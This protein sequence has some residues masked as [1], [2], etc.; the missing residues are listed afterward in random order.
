MK[1]TG[2]ILFLV[3]SSLI[4]LMS[5][6]INYAQQQDFPRIMFLPPNAGREVPMKMSELKID[7]KVVANLATTTMEMTF[8]NDNNSVLE[9]QLYFPLGEGQTVSRF[10]MD[11]NGK[12]REAVVVEKD[13]GRQVFESI[14]REGIDPGLLEKTQ[15]NNFK[16][17][18]YPLPAKGYKKVVI[19]YEQELIDLGKGF[20]YLLPMN[21]KDKVDKFSLRAEVYKQGLQPDM[22]QNELANFNFKK[23]E[24][25]YVA[26]I[27]LQNYVPDKNLAFSLPKEAD[28]QRIFYEE[29]K[30]GDS[31]FYISLLPEI[32]SAEKQL[33]KKLCLLWDVSNSSGSRDIDKEISFL[34]A[35][36]KKIN[37]AEIELVFFSNKAGN[38][39][40]YSVSGGQWNDLKKALKNAVYDGGTQLGA[41]DLSKYNCDEFIFS[42][43]GMSNFGESEIKP[44]NKPVVVIS[45]AASADYSYLNYIAQ[46]SGGVYINLMTK[47]VSQALTLA[48]TNNFRFISAEFDNSITDIHPSISTIV[49]KDFSIAGKINSEKTQ[50][51]LNFGFGSEVKYSKTIAIS[52][53]EHLSESGMVKRIWGQ[54]KIT[55]L[56]MLFDKNEEEIT[57]IGKE[58]SIVT[59]NTS[60]IILDRI[61]DYIRHRIV[62]PDELKEEYFAAINSADQEKI[63]AEKNHIE[64]VV[65]KFEQRKTWWNTEFKFGD[66]TT[67]YT[68]EKAAE[69]EEDGSSEERMEMPMEEVADVTVMSDGIVN[70]SVRRSR[71]KKKDG[72]GDAN[73]GGITLK[74]WEPDTPYL[75]EIKE[76]GES[77]WFDIYLKYKK[78]YANSSAYYLDMADFFIEKGKKDIALRILSNVAEMELEN[79]QLLRILGYRLRQLGYYGLAIMIFKEVLKIREEE[80][81]SYRDLGLVYADN[82]EYQKAVDNLYTVVKRQWD[83]RFP[84]IELIALNEMNSVIATC[85]KQLKLDSIDQR[86]VMNL[87]VD[88]RVI[89]TWDADLCDMDLWVTD[90]NGEKCFYSHPNT[91]IGGLMSRDFTQGYGPEEFILKKAQPGKYKIEVNYYGNSQQVIAGAT[92]IQVLL[93]T[94]F[95]TEHEKNQAITLRLKDEK[96]VIHVGDFDFGE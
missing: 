92:T 74:K 44:G 3:I 41:I 24:D 7:V 33:P 8:Y 26:S 67:K 78:E 1:N 80:P 23:W 89:L 81:Q 57:N 5:S 86:L 51:K 20:V 73:K 85:G 95:G 9:G 10:A 2:K 30:N 6:K 28:R 94:G 72:G 71:E 70:S 61:E 91:Y 36:F 53:A 49:I 88:M 31:Y 42:S 76:K 12:L 21:F 15:G 17:R 18:V 46:S 32:M 69:A 65:T 39:V 68:D 63:T 58:L 62:P 16:A 96:E 48:G 40:K 47:T 38:S 37:N 82:K 25:S 87:P 43:D 22:G 19:A 64:E 75:K 83:G 4:F 77:E 56:D 54:K 50:I 84:D 29:D 52:K 66:G 60:L 59:R 27:E 11:V 13:K 55:E 45:S 35:Y 90:P 14:V 34:D 79:H 93:T